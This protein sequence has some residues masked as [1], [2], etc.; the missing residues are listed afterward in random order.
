L[1]ASNILL[2]ENGRARIADHGLIHPIK[3][4]HM[5]ALFLLDKSYLSP[6]LL[7]AL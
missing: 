4:S 1:R 6:E 5:K 3:P 2:D 7:Q